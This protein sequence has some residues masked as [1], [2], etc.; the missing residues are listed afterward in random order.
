MTQEKEFQ[1]TTDWE[2]KLNRVLQ[3][4]ILILAIIDEIEK[5]NNSNNNNNKISKDDNSNTDNYK[6]LSEEEFCKSWDG[7]NFQDEFYAISSLLSITPE[8]AC[9]IL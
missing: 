1:V 5:Q 9:I 6:Q 3:V 2:T 8:H 7:F 4:M